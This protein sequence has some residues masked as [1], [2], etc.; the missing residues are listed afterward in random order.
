QA[1]PMSLNLG[2]FDVSVTSDIVIK[3]ANVDTT[4]LSKQISKLISEE[5][6]LTNVQISELTADFHHAHKSEYKTLSM[7]NVFSMLAIFLT[8]LGI[9][10]LASFSTLRRQKEVAMRKVLGASRISIVNLLAKEFLVLVAIS[11]VI[12]FPLSY[13]LIGDWLAN[14]NERI[15]QAPWVYVFAA[16]I[17]AIITW[18]TVA[19]LAFKAAS[20]RPTLILRDE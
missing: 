4:I 17:I 16:L 13:W 5:L 9:F 14:F 12:A 10:G 6:H 8:C 2:F 19:S 3:T 15:T 7:V 11:I 1:L 20:T 18:L